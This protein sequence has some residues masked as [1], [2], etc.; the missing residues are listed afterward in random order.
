MGSFTNANCNAVK[1]RSHEIQKIGTSFLFRRNCDVQQVLKAG[2]WSSQTT[3]FAFYTR[4]YSLIYGHL[5]GPCGGSSEATSVVVLIYCILILW[6][7]VTIG[8]I[9]TAL[10]HDADR[11][12]SYKQLCNK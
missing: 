8:F 12:L 6:Q 4:R 10:V 3:S 5:H 1:V 2:T 7:S 11:P 9:W